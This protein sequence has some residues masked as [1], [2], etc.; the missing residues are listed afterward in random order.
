MFIWLAAAS[1]LAY[2][3][4]YIVNGS[5]NT[6]NTETVGIMADTSLLTFIMMSVLLR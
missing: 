1:I 4:Q 6:Q 3:F 2:L 5:F